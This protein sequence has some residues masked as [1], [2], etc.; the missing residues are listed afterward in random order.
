MGMIDDLVAGESVGL[1]TR[2]IGTTR[3]LILNEPRRHNPLS[4]AVRT[5]LSPELANAS[6][7]PAVRAIIITGAGGTFCSGLDIAER[8]GPSQRVLV[9]PH[10]GQAA[11]AATVPVIA[12]VDGVCMTG[13]LELALSCTFIIASNR[14]RFADTHAR[15][16]LLPSWGMTALLP[17]AIG[18]RRAMQMSLTGQFIDASTAKEWGLVNELTTADALLPRALALASDIAACEREPLATQYELLRRT[19]GLRLHDAIQAEAFEAE[20]WASRPH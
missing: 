14:A 17:R 18:T 12:A 8:T 11:L 7:D 1:V 9:R 5:A 3:L 4:I 13:G 19:E 16:S 2:T 10:P 20:R 6:E 15:A